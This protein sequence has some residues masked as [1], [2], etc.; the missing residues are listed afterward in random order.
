[1]KKFYAF[2]AAALAAVSMNAQLYI[3]GD[4]TIGET[5]LGWAPETPY[6][7]TAGTDGNYTVTIKNWKGAKFSTVKGEWNEFNTGVVYFAVTEETIGKEIEL[8]K[9]D[10][11]NSMP[12]WP[13]DW[14]LVFNSDLTKV[15]ATTTTDKPTGPVAI[16]IRGD[17]NG[18]LNDADDATKA[19]W[20]FKL[21]EG[22]ENTF[23][24]VCEGA[25]AI[26]ANKNFKIADG[27]WGVYNYGFGDSEPAAVVVDLE[28]EWF[29]NK[30]ESFFEKDF[31]G[32]ITIEAVP[33][34][35]SMVLCTEKAGVEDIATENA[36]VEYFNLQGIRVANPENGVFIARQ[37]KTI[38]K[39]VK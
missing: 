8:T 23:E 6:E 35:A 11:P 19:Q 17:V 39:V 22:T 36:P 25:T 21:K 37:G 28:Q 31:V 10:G 7:V 2:A 20:Q 13:G 33:S 1:M 18:W 27:D 29:F 30:K 14:T 32:T 26:P 24:L 15:T 34:T 3:C 12:A 5:A 9:N 4:G 16:Y 38:T